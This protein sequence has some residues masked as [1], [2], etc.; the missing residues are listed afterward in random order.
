VVVGTGLGGLYVYSLDLAPSSERYQLR[1]VCN[2][3]SISP[4]GKYVVTGLWNGSGVDW[5]DLTGKQLYSQTAD[6][7]Q[8]FETSISANSNRV[9]SLQYE[10]HQHRNPVVTMWRRDGSKLWQ[11]P[12]G[13]DAFN[14]RALVSA[15]GDY[16]V[17]SFYR[18]II[19]DHAWIPERRLMILDGNGQQ[20]TQIGGLYLSLTLMF[21]APDNKGFI[22]Y[23]GD[24]A[25]Y[26]FDRQG[27]AIS[28]WPLTSAIRTWAV[29]AD[30]KRLVVHTVDDQL[31]ML[32]VR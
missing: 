2:D 18:M 20:V 23:D 4:D 22:A 3:L 16:S 19:R 13:K 7:T 10:N 15:D 24:R 26:R 5:Y 30:N 27:N 9:L 1:G 8:R 32:N 12:I 25:L 6:A 31:T 21:L 29:T 11:T 14:A 28:K 17:A